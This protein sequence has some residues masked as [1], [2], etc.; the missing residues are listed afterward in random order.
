MHHNKHIVNI[1]FQFT[2][3]V[4]KIIWECIC[5]LAYTFNPKG[6]YMFVFLDLIKGYTTYTVMDNNNKYLYHRSFV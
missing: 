2:F 6:K 3:E 5:R 1:N 4:A